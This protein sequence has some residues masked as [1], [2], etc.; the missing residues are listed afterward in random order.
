MEGKR[1]DTEKAID[2]L[3]KLPDESRELVVSLIEQL[4][5]ANGFDDFIR[6]RESVK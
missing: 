6:N 2:T 5:A 3:R 4:A 1:M